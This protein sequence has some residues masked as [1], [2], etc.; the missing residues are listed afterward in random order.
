MTLENSSIEN[1]LLCLQLGSNVSFKEH[2]HSWSQEEWNNFI[3]FSK[4]QG[5]GAVVFQLLLDN[6]LVQELPTDVSKALKKQARLR[7]VI[8]SKMYSD[9]VEIVQA[10]EARSVNVIVLKGPYLANN[11]YSNIAARPM[12]DVDILV[13]HEHIEV[14]TKVLNE[15]G[16]QQG[17]VSK[18]A[19][20]S[21]YHHL[22]PFLKEFSYPV[23]L[24]FN[25]FDK[26]N[27][28]YS[29][30]NPEDFFEDNVFFEVNGSR[31]KALSPERMLIHL[32]YHAAF[33]HHW[34]MGLRNLVD[35]YFYVKT[36]EVDWQ[37]VLEIGEL[38]HTNRSVLLSLFLCHKLLN[39]DLP[40]QI[41]IAIRNEPEMEAMSLWAESKLFSC[42]KR[43]QTNVSRGFLNVIIG[44]KW[45]SKLA[46]LKQAVFLPRQK[47]RQMYGV[48][49]TLWL[50]P[51][52]YVRRISEL[53]TRYSGKAIA[54][55]SGK[56]DMDI[57]KAEKHA[58]DWMLGK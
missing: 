21:S 11:V 49:D 8:A 25:I 35:I 3:D 4:E 37:Q 5:V 57:V 14:A 43:V 32:C 50:T 31:V 15:L 24:H 53:L 45:S 16:Y 23:E 40:H 36:Q 20:S 13:A 17:Q 54:L 30:I 6:N 44:E 33:H 12:G 22:P 39:Y 41:D 51:F 7:R 56:S 52:L 55:L 47:I 48:Q 38:W 1:L 10:M 27:P 46:S 34:N 18:Q 9:I 19:P 26:D 28:A 58:L 42:E 2:C 29:Q